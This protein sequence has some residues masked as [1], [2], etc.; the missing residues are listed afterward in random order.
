MPGPGIP[1][2]KWGT[3]YD[4]RGFAHVAPIIETLLMSGHKLSEKCACSPSVDQGQ[5]FVIMVHNVIH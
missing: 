5:N 1:E 3:F 4:Q 2:I